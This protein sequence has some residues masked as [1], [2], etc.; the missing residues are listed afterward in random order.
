M[1]DIEQ[2][3]APAP[4]GPW[5]HP[6]GGQQQRRQ[7]GT[8]DSHGRVH[9]GMET[10]ADVVSIHG[11]NPGLLSEETRALLAT[12]MDEVDSLR[13]ELEQS[14]HRLQYLESLA[15]EHGYLPVLNRRA[16]L[17]EISTFL[18]EGEGEAVQG[19]LLLFY[20]ENFE[21][22][23]KTCG[24]S[25]AEA[26]LVHMARQ[27]SGSVRSTDVVGAVGGAGILVFMPM[28]TE[29]GALHKREMLLTALADRPIMR[30]GKSMPL[31]VLAVAR[32]FAPYDTADS[33]I[34]ELDA[35]LWQVR[36]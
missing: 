26:A 12:M 18:R 4:A 30:E 22:L 10:P 24:L 31:R 28:A 36:R 11:L 29:V 1:A 35:R 3:S 23:H 19:C 20:L 6:A 13:L 27:I 14:S 17:R 15:D 33:A 25:G 5:K 16:L 21:D 34:I 2:P 7:R 8:Y 32:P 9:G